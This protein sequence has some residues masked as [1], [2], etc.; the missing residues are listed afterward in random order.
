MK[1]SDE[2]TVRLNSRTHALIPRI[3][4]CALLALFALLVGC[5]GPALP[6]VNFAE[7]GWQVHEAAAVWRPRRAAPEL[8]GELLVATHPDGRQLVQFSK[9]ALPLVTAQAATNG[10]NLTSPLRAGRFGGR[11]PATDRVPWFQLTTL[12]PSQPFSPRWTLGIETNGAWRL[13]NPRTGESVE[14]A[15]P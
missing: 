6:P 14:G 4:A 11:P 1:F 3:S 2:T 8:A 9:Q 15:A 7:P 5:A 10:W 12:P 13:S